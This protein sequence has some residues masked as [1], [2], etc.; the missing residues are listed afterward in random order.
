MEHDMHLFIIWN[1]GAN[2]VGNSEPLPH[3]TSTLSLQKDIIPLYFQKTLMYG[4]MA[5][6]AAVIIIWQKW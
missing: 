3:G 6:I 1:L 4:N 2:A 5:T